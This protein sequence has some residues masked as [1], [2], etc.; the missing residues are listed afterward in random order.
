MQIKRERL[1]LEGYFLEFL[2]ASIADLIT[3]LFSS[4]QNSEGSGNYDGCDSS[5]APPPIFTIFKGQNLTF[6]LSPSLLRL[7]A[8]NLQKRISLLGSM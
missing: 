7:L 6:R 3:L 8:K 1:Q 2:K 5:A 4:L